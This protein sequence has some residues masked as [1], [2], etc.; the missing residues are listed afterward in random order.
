MFAALMMLGVKVR[1]VTNLGE[2]CIWLPS[3]LMLFIDS[4]LPDSDRR[5]YADEL[6]AEVAAQPPL[7]A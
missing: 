2:P 5:D 3:E 4:S 7:L 1:E 6:L